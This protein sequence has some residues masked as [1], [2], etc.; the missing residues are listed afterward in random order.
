MIFPTF[1]HYLPLAFD[2]EICP[3]QRKIDFAGLFHHLA[4]NDHFD[5]SSPVLLEEKKADKCY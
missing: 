3:H 5:F 4:V 2:S 1:F